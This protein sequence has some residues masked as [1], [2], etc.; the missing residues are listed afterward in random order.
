MEFNG[1]PRGLRLPT[2][3]LEDFLQSLRNQLNMVSPM[4]VTFLD[5]ELDTYIILENLA[6]LP[7]EKAKIKVI[8]QAMSWWGWSPDATWATKGFETTRYFSLLVKEGSH[9]HHQPAL[10]KFTEVATH[11]GFDPKVAIEIYAVSN[12]KLLSNFE[13]YRDTLY[14]KHRASPGLFK[15]DHWKT[16]SEAEQREEFITWH[17]T[18]SSKF[19]WN[20][21]SKPRVIPMLQGTSEQAVWQICQQGFG[22]VGTTDDGYYGAGVYFTSKLAYADKYARKGPEGTK[23]FWVSMVIPGNSFPVIEHPFA[24]MESTPIQLGSRGRPAVEDTS[25]TLP[26]LTGGTST[27][28][29]PSGEPLILVLLL[30][31]WSPLRELRP[32]PFLSFTPSDL[33]SFLCSFLCSFSSKKKKERKRKSQETF[34]VNDD[35]RWS[36]AGMSRR[37]WKL[38]SLLVRRFLTRKR[39]VEHKKKKRGSP[40][41]G[42]KGVEHREE[43][44]SRKD[45]TQG[46]MTNYFSHIRSACFIL[47]ASASK[48]VRDPRNFE[49]TRS[50]THSPDTRRWFLYVAKIETGF[51]SIIPIPES[52]SKAFSRLRK[53]KSEH[54]IFCSNDLISRSMAAFN[55]FKDPVLVCLEAAIWRNS[56]LFKM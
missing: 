24:A 35:L 52:S 23:P 46:Q 15:K 51:F 55:S 17:S 45:R 11:L 2:N 6:D 4:S 41:F 49:D 33:S 22:V 43:R 1:E 42:R 54:K 36:W 40:M 8:A 32:F 18:Y 14:A 50:I 10:T 48:I 27:P 16:M 9:I 5:P 53:L 37:I 3:S 56:S 26:W 20:D 25:R 30:M 29:F 13:N 19:S 44:E 39:G 28:P 12:E 21:Q 34:A 31:S 47:T 38:L 7:A